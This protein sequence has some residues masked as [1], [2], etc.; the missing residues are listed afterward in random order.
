MRRLMYNLLA[1]LQCLRPIGLM[2]N[3]LVSNIRAHRE[4][5]LL[6]KNMYERLKIVSSDLSGCNTDSYTFNGAQDTAQTCCK[7]T[8]IYFQAIS[9]Q[10]KFH[11]I[12]LY[13]GNV[14]T[15]LAPS[16]LAG[17]SLFL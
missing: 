11:C 15:V 13:W 7:D 5:I 16:V 1:I 3:K 9:Q 4:H 10:Q 2:R 8:T 6:T 14:V 17:S 12:D